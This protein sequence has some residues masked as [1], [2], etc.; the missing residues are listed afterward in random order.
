[1][2]SLSARASGRAARKAGARR[3]RTKGLRRR[4]W[5][6]EPGA[7][8][9]PASYA[10]LPIDRADLRANGSRRGA[11]RTRDVE[12]THAADHELHDSMLGR[13]EG[14]WVALDGGTALRQGEGQ[15]G[16]LR[17]IGYE[18]LTLQPGG[19]G[20]SRCR[21]G[22]TRTFAHAKTPRVCCA[23]LAARSDRCKAR[24]PLSATA[25]RGAWALSFPVAC[26]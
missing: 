24:R 6:G 13:R 19:R 7:K 10:E 5:R 1:M 22:H 21:R 17:P 3:R 15:K 25:Q 8:L 20:E 9:A 4:R 2:R 12:V 23:H 26:D 16:K 11:T 18:A 14:V